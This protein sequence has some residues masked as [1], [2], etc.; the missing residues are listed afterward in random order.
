MNVPFHG[1]LWRTLGLILAMAGFFAVVPHPFAADPIATQ[2][3]GAGAVFETLQIASGTVYRDV[4]VRSVNNRTL[5]ISHAGG[6]AAVRLR[7]LPRDLQIAFGYSAEAEAAADAMLRQAQALQQKRIEEQLVL[8]KRSRQAASDSSEFDQLLQRF[9]RPVELTAGVDLR[10]R[11][12]ELALNV[13]NQGRRPSCAIFAI[14]SALE[15]QNALLSGRVERFSEEYLLWAT[16]KTL[17]RAPRARP[18]MPAGADEESPEN[19][20]NADEGFALSE[21]VTALRAYGIPLQESLPYS[22]LSTAPTPEVMEEARNRRRVSVVALPGHDRSMVLANLIH[23]LHAGVPVAVGMRW[24]AGRTMNTSYLNAQIP[25][26]QGGHA[27]TIVGYENKTG[28]IGDTVFI[29]KN[30]WGAK[31]GAA[32]FGYATYRYLF[33]NLTDTAL[34]EVSMGNDKS[35]GK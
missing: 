35:S 13:K 23:A 26:D 24:P 29:F 5:M 11:F 17:N 34:L 6:L 12:F 16:C 2:P 22:F 28:A 20:D 31:W 7:D 9:G 1:N 3:L 14:V 19:L 15:Y 10:P 32:G 33:N 27:V 4:K 8:K 21:V 30:S 18:D 25:R